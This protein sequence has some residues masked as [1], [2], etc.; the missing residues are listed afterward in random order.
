MP[1]SRA[2]ARE[3]S[4]RKTLGSPDA[5]RKRTPAGYSRHELEDLA[6]QWY[7]KGP[8]SIDKMAV[9]MGGYPIKF[10]MALVDVLVRAERAL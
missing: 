4:A 5:L 1:P 3:E 2:K 10:V 7:L 8:A 9:T 6:I